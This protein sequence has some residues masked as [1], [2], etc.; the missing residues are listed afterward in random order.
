M[1]GIKLTP[2]V[3][4]DPNTNRAIKEIYSNLNKL[5][6][7]LDP[8]SHIRSNNVL[9]GSVR[10]VYDTSEH[11]FKLKGKTSHGWASIA[12][13]RD[14]PTS[15]SSLFDIEENG[16]TFFKNTLSILGSRT[17]S[18]STGALE[19]SSNAIKTTNGSLT[20]TSD[21]NYTVN[22]TGYIQFDPGDDKRVWV[23]TNNSTRATT[24][25]G[26]GFEV[27]YDYTGIA[28][29]G[30]GVS[31]KAINI[32]MNCGDITTQVGA[33]SNYGL[34]NTMVG[35]T[36]GTQTNYG[37][38][39]RL[40]GADTN[41]GL[42][43]FVPDGELD[44]QCVS[45]ADN[46]DYF[47]ISVTANG[48]TTLST[49]DD[50]GTAANLT[51]D[52]DGDI[53]LDAHANDIVFMQDGDVGLQFRITT[54]TASYLS[55]FERGGTTTD[56]Y[57]QI[58]TEEHGATTLA[59]TDAAAAAAD[60]TLNADG[61]LELTTHSAKKVWIDANKAETSSTTQYGLQVDFDHTGITASGQTINNNMF[62]VAG[63]SN[64]A[65]HVGTVN[66]FGVRI[67]MVGGT[68]GTQN[69][70]G[71]YNKISGADTNTGYWGF[72]PDGGIDI[73][74]VSSADQGDYCTI[75]TTTNGATTIAT[76]DGGGDAASLTI[77]T[78]GPIV[79]DSHD[80]EFIAKKA[81]TEF[82]VANSAYAGMIIG[83]TRIANNSTTNG[84]QW[85][86]S[87]GT[88]TVLQTAQGTNVSVTFVAPPSGNV[89]IQFSCVLYASSRTLEFALS[90]NASFSEVHETH[91]Y[92]NGAQSSDETDTNSIVISFAVTGLTAGTSYTYFI[93]S[94]ETSAGTSAIYH[95]RHRS[96]GRHYPPI[97]VKAIALPGTITTGE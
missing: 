16:K 78:D 65:V 42:L 36:S 88:L 28:A 72:T 5:L 25:T 14:S 32:A 51:L 49:V 61:D 33:L 60:L 68:D 81:G 64:G 43:S 59:T 7:S 34:Y 47:G 4:L 91:T 30:E 6:I 3:I 94:A 41:I 74:L 77:D 9:D 46:D 31:N 97:I 66:N 45:S 23:D 2:P 20:V 22:S 96:T 8:D 55:L 70:F 87:D 10:A 48:A 63:N 73:K 90:D 82:S 58:K 54:G 86:D 40:I 84:D 85:I 80:G 24:G 53:N 93:G 13:Q 79:L 38:Y 75:S 83:Y 52:V 27:D 19:L 12:A 18:S 35:G 62:Y 15:S 56:D 1:S 26:I 67:A 44:I 95:G 21:N 37:I 92:D 39:N 69:N 89:E 17:T 11:R 50:T 29:S 57:F 76:E 71:I